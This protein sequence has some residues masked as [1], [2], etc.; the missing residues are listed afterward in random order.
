MASITSNRS[1]SHNYAHYWRFA[2]FCCFAAFFYSHP[3]QL[4]VWPLHRRHNERD[5]VLNHWRLE[6]L[7]NRLF[8]RRSK[9][10][11][12]LCVPGLCEGNLPVTGGFPSQRVSNAEKCFH[13]MTSSC[14]GTIKWFPGSS[15]IKLQKRYDM[16]SMINNNETKQNKVELMLLHFVINDI[17]LY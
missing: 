1:T 16:C 11:S 10:T 13:L 15:G 14:T 8:W 3:T 6:C 17:K 7:L 2:A 5:G 9:K 12:K 4:L